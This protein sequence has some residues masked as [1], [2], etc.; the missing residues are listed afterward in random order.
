MAYRRYGTLRTVADA[1]PVFEEMRELKRQQEELR[2]VHGP[3]I[4]GL[5]KTLAAAKKALKKGLD[6]RTSRYN[7]L[8]ALLKRFALR[9]REHLLSLQSG[10][11]VRVDDE[12]GTIKYSL[13]PPHIVYEGQG[14]PEAEAELIAELEEQ[15]NERFVRVIKEI[16]VEALE[17]EPEVAK[18]LGFSWD[19]D[20]KITIKP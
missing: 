20:E 4:A 7:Q 6:R 1:A 17:R 14:D 15:G 10:K 8:E 9:K 2:A 19:Q 11:T 12:G 5:E 3:V 16:D 18:E 13:N